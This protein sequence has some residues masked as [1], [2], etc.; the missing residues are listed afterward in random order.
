[1]GKL[2]KLKD[3]WVQLQKLC[4]GNVEEAQKLL[5]DSWHRTKMDAVGVINRIFR[6]HSANH[7]FKLSEEE[8]ERFMGELQRLFKTFPGFDL[9]EVKKIVGPGEIKIG[10]M[11]EI[12]NFIVS[13]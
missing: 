9:D 1:M 5:K 10:K 3:G 2:Q 7:G 8:K 4:Q 6:S 11:E 12:V 13:L